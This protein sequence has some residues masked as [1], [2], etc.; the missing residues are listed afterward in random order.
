MAFELKKYQK[1]CLDEL[2]KFLKGSWELRSAKLAFEKQVPR[3]YYDVKEK[4]L[5]GLPYV[6]VRVPTGGGKTA[7]AAYSVGT[8]AKN[9]LRTE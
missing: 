7:L 1:R 9:L 8:A 2:A 4:E 3:H 6:C 5:E